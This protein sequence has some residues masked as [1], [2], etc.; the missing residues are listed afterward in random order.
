RLLS[1]VVGVQQL[2]QE[3]RS[4]LDP[5]AES[6]IL[7]IFRVAD[8]RLPEADVPAG[9]VQIPLL[10]AELV[11][12][13]MPVLGEQRLEAHVPAVEDGDPRAGVANRHRQVD[14]AVDDLD[15]CAGA[16]ERGAMIVAPA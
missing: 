5:F 1:L 11:A 12:L 10:R 2:D 7:G 14:V 6:S 4:R 3:D 8:R 16:E 15:M 9:Y 13:G